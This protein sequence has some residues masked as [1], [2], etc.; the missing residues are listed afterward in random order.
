M[1]IVWLGMTTNWCLDTS[2]IFIDFEDV[3]SEMVWSF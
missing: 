3:E 1:I 2:R